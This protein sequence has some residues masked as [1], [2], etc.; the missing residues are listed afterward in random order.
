LSR[1][2]SIPVLR[3][4]ALPSSRD[5]A[6]ISGDVE[7]AAGERLEQVTSIPVAAGEN[8]YRRYGFRD[9]ILKDRARF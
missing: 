6:S 7:T 9:M 3:R 5:K 2:T 1:L 8:E 4:L